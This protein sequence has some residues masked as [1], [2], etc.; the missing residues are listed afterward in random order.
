MS[1]NATIPP[2]L[3]QTCFTYYPK[4]VVSP[5]CHLF[6]TAHNA[7]P[8]YFRFSHLC[9]SRIRPS[10]AYFCLYGGRYMVYAVC[11][12]RRLE[13]TTDHNWWLAR[14]EPRHESS[15]DTTTRGIIRYLYLWHG[16]IHET[17]QERICHATKQN[18]LLTARRLG[19]RWH[20]MI[21]NIPLSMAPQLE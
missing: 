9:S 20:E 14:H 16:R 3:I 13:L 11:N 10:S 2:S 15:Y 17:T 7:S 19:I 18:M 12:V 6:K 1:D 8:F 5:Y 21:A 4:P